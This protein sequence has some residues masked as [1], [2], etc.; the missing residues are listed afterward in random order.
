MAADD[1]PLKPVW[2]GNMFLLPVQTAHRTYMDH[3]VAS[4]EERER[5]AVDI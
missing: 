3:Y 4:R 2:V 1:E 5:G